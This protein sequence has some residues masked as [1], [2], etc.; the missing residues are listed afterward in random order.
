MISRLSQ[1]VE[2]FI[3]R[4]VQLSPVQRGRYSA[5]IGETTP[6]LHKLCA[7]DL[8]LLKKRITFS[9]ENPH[10]DGRSIVIPL[11]NPIEIDGKPIASLR[12]KGVFPR[13][14]SNKMVEK[15]TE[16]FG[17]PTRLFDISANI[18]SSRTGR[19]DLEYSAK[20]TM[21]Y[22]RVEKETATALILGPQRT[23][24]LLA[25]GL[26]DDLNFNGLPP[27]FVIYGLERGREDVRVRVHLYETVEHSGVIP[28]K[29]DDLAKS[30]GKL[31]R[32]A[33][34][35]N[36]LHR[37]SHLGNFGLFN[38]GEARI[39]DFDAGEKLSNIAKESRL[40]H[41]YLDVARTIYDFMDHIIY[42][43]KFDD[44][45]S[46]IPI[47]LTPLVPF[48]LWGYFRGD[49][50]LPV[51]K[52]LEQFIDKMEYSWNLK[53]TFVVLPSIR[54]GMIAV[55]GTPT[56]IDAFVKLWTTPVGTKTDMDDF[57]TN[58]FFVLLRGALASLPFCGQA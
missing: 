35:N 11:Q 15:Y 33:H 38:Q 16:G 32:E 44:D 21:S 47:Y 45:Y 50:S 25:F 36:I 23:D 48:F 5:T 20:G 17:F 56:P 8:E 34:E 1:K 46:D 30:T 19:D 4:R 29:A 54:N 10:D 3:G 26:Y 14:G 24:P 53:E 51:V 27:G 49:M 12:L 7:G 55:P 22:Q 31:L 6:F 9:I 13:V 28:P 57:K 2:P 52:G 58:P 18:I 41:L 40:T 43:E 39:V 42:P 37:S